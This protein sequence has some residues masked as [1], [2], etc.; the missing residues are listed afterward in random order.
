MNWRLRS[1][2]LYLRDG[3]MIDIN[4]IPKPLRFARSRRRRIRGWT[5][6]IIGAALFLCVPFVFDQ[7]LQTE[8]ARLRR[9]D[10]QFQE[11]VTDQRV[12]VAAV[13]IQA[14]QTLL[15]L[16]RAQALRSK[17][18]WSALYGLIA[19]RI[20]DG[21]WL[22]SIATDPASPTG[23]GVRPARSSS[24]GAKKPVG[25]APA[26]DAPRRLKIAGFASNPSEPHQ[27]VTNLK[28]NDVFR[29]VSLETSRSEQALDGWYFRF[30]LLCEW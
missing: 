21:C 15:R 16:N 27:F 19:E 9:Q 23:G 10:A 18:A 2:L 25:S 30:E 5:I 13:T 11:Q 24:R 14:D 12:R 20:P 4:F 3:V 26:I 17:R 7:Y 28:M 1:A 8:V 29:N 6:W 22:T